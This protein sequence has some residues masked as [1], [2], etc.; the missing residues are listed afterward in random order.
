M[1]LRRSGS[2]SCFMQHHALLA[3][4]LIVCLFLMCMPGRVDAA[5]VDEPDFNVAL[6][7]DGSGS[8]SSELVGAEAT[9]PANMR[10][11]AISLFFG[12]SYQRRQLR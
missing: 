9:D 8:L 6:V 12:P 1:Q 11:D 3:A 2:F 4:A 10:Y 7:I 5:N